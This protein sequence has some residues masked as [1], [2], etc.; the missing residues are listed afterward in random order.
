MSHDTHRHLVTVWNPRYASDAME[1]HLRVLLDWDAKANAGK[2][3]DEMVYVWWGKVRSGQ[4]QQAMPHL[5]AI[6]ALGRDAA[7]DPDDSRETHLYLTDYRSLYVADVAR[8]VS[9]DPRESDAA[10]VP[11]YY[12][13]LG[14]NCDCWFEISDI[15]L[16]VKDDLEG[17]AEELS[18]LRNTR[19]HDR[20][21]SL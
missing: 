14:L 2:V 15:R 20:P 21:V 5:D 1:S 17:V 6:I 7:D 8:I 4:R 16:L 10:H 18:R 9:N 11:G 19:Y 3:D 12:T 13:K